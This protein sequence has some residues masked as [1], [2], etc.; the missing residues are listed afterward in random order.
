MNANR[1]LVSPASKP[2]KPVSYF[3]GRESAAASFAS[4]PP[5]PTAHYFQHQQT[6]GV[7][8]FNPL[9]AHPGGGYYNPYGYQN[10]GNESKAPTTSFQAIN[11]MNLGNMSFNAFAG[12]YASDSAHER[13]DQDFDL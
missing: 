8:A 5:V 4:Q 11:T 1:S 3:P 2:V 13:V 12:S 7:R 9:C 10:Y 6:M